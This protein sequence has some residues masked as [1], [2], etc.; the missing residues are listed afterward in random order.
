MDNQMDKPAY[1]TPKDHA[2]A[3]ITSENDSP[4]EVALTR[5]PP[6]TGC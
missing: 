3:P 5:S 1:K 4:K 2:G 6:T